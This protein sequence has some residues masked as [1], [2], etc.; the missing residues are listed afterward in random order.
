MSAK[1]TTPTVTPWANKSEFFELKN[2]FFPGL[3]DPE[4]AT[5][6]K[7]RAIARTKAYMIRG[8]VPHA[9]E[10]T[11]MLV[12]AQI[13]DTPSANAIS[14]RLAMSTAVIR[15]V[16]GMIDPHQNGSYV[17]P[18]QVIA[19]EIGLPVF[20]VDLRHTCTHETLPS[21]RE[22]RAGVDEAVTWLHTNYWSV[23]GAEAN[24]SATP[25]ANSDEI[26]EIFRQWRRLYR[27]N[28]DLKALKD[29]SNPGSKPEMRFAFLAKQIVLYYS[30]DPA[31]LFATMVHQKVMH[32]KNQINKALLLPMLKSLPSEL[33][34][35]L[36]LYMFDEA[37]R[38]DKHQT[39]SEELSL[40]ANPVAEWLEVFVEQDM[41]SN[42][43]KTMLT[44]SR[45]LGRTALNLLDIYLMHKNDPKIERIR[46]TMRDV[47]L[48]GE[49]RLETAIETQDMVRLANEYKQRVMKENRKRT[50]GDFV[51]LGAE[52][53]ENDQQGPFKR[54]RVK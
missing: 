4:A 2:W 40:N 36:F 43:Q 17:I 38:V 24:E 44:C 50:G 27:D 19:R 3:S 25:A 46:Q 29:L 49:A 51:S 12:S 30:S 7:Q 41:L 5:A 48:S 6:S 15:F 10:C 47:V 31:T 20:L 45:S 54:V 18:M 26:K 39:L 52:E 23:R 9:V 42:G 35:D 16:N 33:L 22:L 32:T 1:T 37:E 13:E 11:G 34:S 14:T 53:V 28:R 8:N 21:L